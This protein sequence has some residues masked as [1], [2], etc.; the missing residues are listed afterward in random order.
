ME[1]EK[2]YLAWRDELKGL[3]S[4]KFVRELVA[5]MGGSTGIPKLQV[6]PIPLITATEGQ[7][8]FMI[9]LSSFGLTY[10]PQT[11]TVLVQKG[12]LL[13]NPNGDYLIIGQFVVLTEAVKA[14]TTVGIWV[15]KNVP[16]GEEGSVSGTVIAP[17]TIPLNRLEKIPESNVTSDIPLHL[18]INENGGLRITYDDDGE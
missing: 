4:E 17:G 2:H 18:S 6:Y 1:E 14:G 13:L 11:D 15:W 9:D 3:A 12:N 10:D 7:T 16:I 8:E 5:S